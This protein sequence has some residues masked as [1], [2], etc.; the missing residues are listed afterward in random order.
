MLADNKEDDTLPPPPPDDTTEDEQGQSDIPPPPQH[1]GDTSDDDDDDL[2][3][4]ETDFD[5]T[6]DQAE[7]FGKKEL[8]KLLYSYVISNDNKILQNKDEAADLAAQVHESLHASCFY[9]IAIF[10]YEFSN[11]DNEEADFLDPSWADETTEC[12]V[13]LSK[14]QGV[15]LKDSYSSEE[16]KAVIAA[17]CDA[18]IAKSDEPVEVLI[19]KLCEFAKGK[20]NSVMAMSDN[21]ALR[22]SVSANP[23]AEKNFKLLPDDMKDE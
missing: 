10:F 1:D 14:E 23:L 21:M 18:M 5:M 2:P 13:E 7:S 16:L 17:K 3:P 9:A 12:V 20:S 15:D 22:M 19:P 4:P 8:L 6:A 11:Q